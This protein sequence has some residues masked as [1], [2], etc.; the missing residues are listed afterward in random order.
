MRSKIPAGGEHHAPCFVIPSNYHWF[1]DLAISQIITRSLENLHRKLPK[2]TVEL[3]EIARE[4]QTAAEEQS[5][6][7]K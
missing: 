4:Y 2:P 1:R 7:M 6:R 5:A 3:A